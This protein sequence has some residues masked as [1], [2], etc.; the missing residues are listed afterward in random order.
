MDSELSQYKNLSIELI[1]EDPSINNL[2]DGIIY[3]VAV[4]NEDFI[5]A[6]DNIVYNLKSCQAEYT[7]CIYSY[8]I[9]II[10]NAIKSPLK[11]LL[12]EAVKN[13]ANLIL[14]INTPDT[15]ERK[16]I[17]A[18][19]DMS[20]L[21]VV[22]EMMISKAEI[23]SKE[24]I[25]EAFINLAV[26]EPK[27]CNALLEGF[28]NNILD[29]F[30]D[31]IEENNSFLSSSLCSMIF[32]SISTCNAVSSYID[33]V[34]LGCSHVTHQESH[35]IFQRFVYNCKVVRNARR[36]NK[37]SPKVDVAI[38]ELRFVFK[39]LWGPNRCYDSMIE[40][41]ID[42]SNKYL[43]ESYDNMLNREK[44][45]TLSKI[46]II[47]EKSD[48]GIDKQNRTNGY[49]RIYAA[50]KK[51]RDKKVYERKQLIHFGRR[52]ACVLYMM[53]LLD[54]KQRNCD[55]DSIDL[56]KNKQLFCD[57]WKMIY[58]DLGHSTDPLLQTLLKKN[59]KKNDVQELLK[60]AH[61]AIREALKK[62]IKDCYGE[63]PLPFIIT[64]QWSHIFILA[65]NIVIPE[66]MS[67]MNILY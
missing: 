46:D 9:S 10:V 66:E 43:I 28:Y 44:M 27:T 14:P 34:H 16:Y 36:A 8:D 62:V 4:Y 49:Y 5:N 33:P 61:N 21:G 42:K 47:I 51:E 54:R 56:I 31:D 3:V 59:P 25:E 12:H 50:F 38:E 26:Q 40:V 17:V 19:S 20:S 63:N 18:K 35:E 55:V 52:P 24:S 41:F 23:L 1:C 22:I 7:Q 32:P 67:N 60:N 39:Y 53:Y 15:Y 65:D 48:E 37:T 11:G 13:G 30:H 29:E 64:N 58:Q 45:A 6:I 57:L 2:Y